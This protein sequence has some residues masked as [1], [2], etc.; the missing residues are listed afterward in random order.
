MTPH[1]SAARVCN[2]KTIGTLRE[3]A[4]SCNM[5]E[6][7][8]RLHSKH[9]DMATHGGKSYSLIACTQAY[10]EVIVQMMMKPTRKVSSSIHISYAEDSFSEN[11]DMYYHV[12]LLNLKYQ[13]PPSGT[14]AWHGSNPPKG[15]YN[16][17]LLKYNKFFALLGSDW[18]SLIN[19]NVV[20][21]QSAENTNNEVLL[22]EILWEISFFGFTEKNVNKFIKKLEK[23]A[24]EVK[25]S[26]SKK[27]K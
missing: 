13:E 26:V 8:T 16:A 23:S 17:N 24:K 6:V 10:R 1:N 11:G 7:Y 25:K 4:V 14:L 18:T 5:N 19:S 27:K 9:T 20:V 12:D 21:D 2:M 3:L 22:A 15:Y